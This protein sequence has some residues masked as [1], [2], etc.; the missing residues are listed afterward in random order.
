VTEVELKPLADQVVVIT[1]ASSGI[2]LVTARLAAKR[3]ARV[4]LAARSKPDL[5][6]A[7]HRIE[8]A[9]GEAVY[10]VADVANPHEVEA[11]AEEATRAFGGFDS[12]V[13]NAGVSIYGTLQEVPLADARRLF[14]T[15]YWGMVHGSLVAAAYLRERGGA[16]INVGS[17][18]S[19][20]SVPLQGHYA[21]SKHAVKGFTDTLRME[22]EKAE[23]PISVSLVKPAAIATPFARHARSYLETEPNLPP[24][25][26]DPQVVARTILRC[27]QKPVR[28]IT[29]GGGGRM[30]AAMGKVAP[31]LTERYMEAALFRQQK[32]DRPSP[33][34][35]RDSLER[36]M[37]G[38][39][40]E[41]MEYDRHVMRTSAYTGA[42][43]HPIQTAIAGAFLGTAAVLAFRRDREP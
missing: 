6:R 27:A 15:N 25:V 30:M 24:P 38:D 32:T 35:R 9:G 41:R 1:G 22:L 2:G 18:V 36:P 11:I 31:R 13:N 29:V 39:G 37:K 8:K 40:G 42:R 34:P 5:K 14:D 3:G 33:K 28:E 17:I 12:W 7:V 23:A 21:A 43:L 26:Y 19:D 4:V 20:L 16:I 10:V